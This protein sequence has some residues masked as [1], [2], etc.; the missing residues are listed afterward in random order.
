MKKIAKLS[1]TVLVMALF[2]SLTFIGCGAEETYTVWTAT[3]TNSAFA[4]AFNENEISQSGV[5]IRSSVQDTT[6][7]E[8]KD[9]VISATKRDQFVTAMNGKKDEWTED[10][11]TDYLSGAGLT[12]N[13]SDVTSWFIGKER[14]AWIAV[15]TGDNVNIIIK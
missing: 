6:T 10:E 5:Y 14:C 12:K 8:W 7:G 13:T 1:L 3:M 2:L 9:D 4:T 11:I 15:R